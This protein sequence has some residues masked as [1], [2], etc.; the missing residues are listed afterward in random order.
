MYY[1]LTIIKISSVATS[2]LNY[3]KFEDLDTRY[4]AFNKKFFRKNVRAR[5]LATVA[6]EFLPPPHNALKSN[7]M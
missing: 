5:S 3:R 7:K 1:K 6:V 2:V 4:F